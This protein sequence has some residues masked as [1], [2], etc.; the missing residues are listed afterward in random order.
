[1]H[2]LSGNGGGGGGGGEEEIDPPAKLSK[3]GGGGGLDKNSYG[4]SL[5][6]LILGGFTKNQYIKR[7]L[8]KKCRG[9]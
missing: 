2:P 3:W 8:S 5:R 7:E 9:A 4:G 6:N 1:M